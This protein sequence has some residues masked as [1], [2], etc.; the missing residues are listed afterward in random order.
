MFQFKPDKEG[1]T[2]YTI[3]EIPISEKREIAQFY[4][5]YGTQKWEMLSV[6]PEP[7]SE[8]MLFFKDFDALDCR[9]GRGC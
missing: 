8:L 3:Y 9:T 5:N 6:S 4:L 7:L 1:E 2:E